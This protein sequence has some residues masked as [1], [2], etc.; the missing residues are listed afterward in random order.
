MLKTCI[1]YWCGKPVWKEAG[2][3]NRA[4]KEGMNLFCNKRCFGMD[5]RKNKSKDQKV[6][7]KR[8]YDQRYR[9][10]NI[11]IIK[12]R[13]AAYYAAN[14]DREKEAAWRKANM[15]K[16]IEYCRTPRYKKWKLEYDKRRMKTNVRARLG[17]P[18]WTPQSVVESIEL[19][20]TLTKE[21]KR[22]HK[23]S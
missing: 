23:R 7:E 11:A 9:A 4:K 5:R 3:I 20:K 2:A 15:R 1:C 6:S 22:E 12:A 14:H 19:F 8:I 10:K 16:H 21:I 13:K 18:Q 17:L